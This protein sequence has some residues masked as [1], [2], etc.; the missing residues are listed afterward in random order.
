VKKILLFFILILVFG[1]QS[2]DKNRSKTSTIDC[3]SV[4]FS[5]ENNVFSQGDTNSLDLEKIEYK[6]TLNNFGFT[7][8]CFEDPINNNYFLDLLILVEPITPKDENIN[9]P[10][11]AIL[12]DNNNKIIGKDYFRIV[13]KLK[14]YNEISNSK[15]TDLATTL[16][17]ITPYNNKV[18]SLIIGFVKIK[19]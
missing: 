10:I 13:D 14:Y 7:T 18:S 11:F 19:K 12:Y 9:L 15:S 17:I 4:F 2:I 3:P 5:S 6:A 1:C 8:S 16:K